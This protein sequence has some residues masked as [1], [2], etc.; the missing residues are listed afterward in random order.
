[1]KALSSP[2]NPAYRR[3][4]QLASRPRAVRELRQTLAEGLHLARTALDA[5][6][7]IVA[8]LLR[9]GARGEAIEGL[10]GELDAAV[11]RYEL[12]P[13]LY[14][15]L[16]PVEHGA[17]VML[18]IGA[19]DVDPPRLLAA[20]M[21]FLDGL[22]DPGNVGTLLRTAAAAGVR[23]VLA[24][25]GTA[26]LW[27]PK[28]LRAAMGAHFHLSLSEA[29]A[30]E[31]LPE[32]LRGE[33]VAAVAH[34]AQSLWTAPLPAGAIGWVFGGEG[35]GPSAATLSICNRRL[36]VPTEGGV[37]SLNVAAAAAIC[38]FERRRRR[39]GLADPA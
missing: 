37:E 15:R 25:P 23:H 13:A 1:M 30:P 12:A 21:V 9:R 31:R 18:A 3:W 11:E 7:P 19:R 36:S 8:V 32:T 33:W 14:D 34:D 29:V 24:G 39:E 6:H 28:V 4:L 20:D 27:A 22:Q 35:A 10:L 16:A 26:A 17:G 2:A 38:L 5:G